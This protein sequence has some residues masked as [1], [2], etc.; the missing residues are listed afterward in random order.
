LNSLS[1]SL[2]LSLS[3][4]FNG[5]WM[6]EVVLTTGAINR[7]KLQ[8]SRHHQQTNIH[9]PIDCKLLN[10]WNQRA[11]VKFWTVPSLPWLWCACCCGNSLTVWLWLIVLT[12]YYVQNKV[13]SHCRTWPYY[14]PT[15]RVGHI[16][17][18]CASDVRLSIAYI[19]PKSRTERPRKT[20]I[21]TGQRSSFREWGHIVA[22][23]RT[24][25]YWLSLWVS[26]GG[27]YLCIRVSSEDSVLMNH[28]A[29]FLMQQFYVTN[30]NCLF[31]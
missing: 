14:A 3:I 6:M 7:A 23:S 29:Q 12:V 19:G 18:W 24:A 25:C 16:K 15:P 13:L 27:Q 30:W 28:A 4:R 2:S 1:L 9:Q 26:S 17:W 22:A 21:G 31:Y 8:S 20:D 10:Q 11:S 5:H